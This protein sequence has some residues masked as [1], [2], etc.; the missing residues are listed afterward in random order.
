MSQNLP[1]E[2][3][4]VEPPESPARR[5][6]DL[7]L[8]TITVAETRR[9]YERN[10]NR[11]IDWCEDQQTDPLA[12][13]KTHVLLW[14]AELAPA[15]AMSSRAQM[16]SA[17]SSWYDWMISEDRV[18]EN[19]TKISKHAKPK[20][21]KHHSNTIGLSPAQ[22]RELQQLADADSTSSSAIVAVLLQC[23]LRVN[24]LAS[25]NVEDVTMDRGHQVVRIVG[26]G[27]R[28]EWVPLPPAVM[29]RIRAHLAERNETPM[30]VLPALGPGAREPRPLV[31]A[32]NGRRITELYVWRLLRRLAKRSAGDLAAVANRLH[33]HVTRHTAITTA[34]D[35]NVPLRDVQDWA[36]HRSPETTRRYD[37]SRNNPDRSPGY[38]ISGLLT[39]ETEQRPAD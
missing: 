25:A 32:A 12:A 39:P 9:A 11:W 24:E 7:Y 5:L 27:N 18:T 19:P 26:K 28:P 30:E 17:V 16:L 4:V 20:V 31:R 8:T 13:R 14:L 21:D 37:R 35:A 38:R 3:R 10:L 6:V 29:E 34:L 36:R 23:A 15:F 1:V 33:P 2:A 22:A